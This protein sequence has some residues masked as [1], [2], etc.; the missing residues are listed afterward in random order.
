MFLT[1]SWRSGAPSAQSPTMLETFIMT[2]YLY[3]LLISASHLHRLSSLFYVFFPYYLLS[4]Y[5]NYYLFFNFYIFFKSISIK[6]RNKNNI[7]RKQR[8]KN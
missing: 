2:L 8:R 5:L 7:V 1:P 3:S 6:Q 4:F